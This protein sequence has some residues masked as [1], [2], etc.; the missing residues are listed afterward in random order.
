MIKRVSRSLPAANTIVWYRKYYNFFG[1]VAGNQFSEASASSSCA[2]TVLWPT[3]SD[4]SPGRYSSGCRRTATLSSP[5]N[6]DDENTSPRPLQQVH[7]PPSHPHRVSLSVR[8]FSYLPMIVRCTLT[9]TY[10]T[11]RF[12]HR[13]KNN[14]K[15]KYCSSCSAD[16]YPHSRNFNFFFLNTYAM[17]KQTTVS[18]NFCAPRFIDLIRARRHYSSGLSREGVLTRWAQYKN[19]AICA[20][21]K[22]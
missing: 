16:D 13:K 2:R 11:H 4:R 12:Y 10:T 7:A 22:P 19:S 18:H 1:T 17:T 15:P 14:P 5:S 9:H 21:H 8:F 6:D 3:C 20:L